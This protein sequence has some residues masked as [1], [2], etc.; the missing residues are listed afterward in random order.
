MRKKYYWK[1]NTAVENKI[2]HKQMSFLNQFRTFNFYSFFLLRF[3]VISNIPTSSTILQNQ[4]NMNESTRIEI[5]FSKTKLTRLLVISILFVLAGA[6]IFQAK[7]NAGNAIFN[8]EIFRKVVGLLS[9]LMGGLGSYFSSKKLFNSE[10][11]LI[12]DNDGIVDNSGAVSLGRIPW[13]DITAIKETVVK[14]AFA[15]NQK[16]IIVMLRNPL[17]YISSQSNSV[18]RRLLTLNF[19]KSGSPVHITTNGL[20]IKHEE[21]R[22]LLLKR[23]SEYEQRNSTTV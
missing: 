1:K 10:P 4:E 17:D 11:G 14:A 19:N 13:T 16:F 9:I 15:T 7:T 6:W 8:S 12:V 3:F 22:D 21:L 20:Q 5:P 2:P 18:T 23:F